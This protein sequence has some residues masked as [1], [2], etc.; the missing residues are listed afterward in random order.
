M[1]QKPRSTR[2]IILVLACVLLCG[3]YYCYDIPAS[4]STSLQHYFKFTEVKWNYILN[5]LYSVYSIPNLVLPICSGLLIDS[6]SPNRTII[7][8]SSMLMIAQVV[9]TMA[10]HYK[11]IPLMLV[12]RALFGIGGEALEVAQAVIVTTW[13]PNNAGLALGLTLTAA[14]L[15]TAANDNI[16]PSIYTHTKTPDAVNLVGVIVAAISVMAAITIAYMTKVN[17]QVDSLVQA[18]VE[19]QSLLTESMDEDNASQ[20]SENCDVASSSRQATSSW[21]SGVHPAFW[22]LCLACIFCYATVNPYMHILQGYLENKYYPGDPVFAARVMSIPDLM[23]AVG[24]PL[25]GLLLDRYGFRSL[26]LPFSSLLILCVHVIVMNTST[27]TPIPYM[28][29]LGLAYSIFAAA[30]WPC[31]PALID[32]QYRATAYGIL[33]VAMNIALTITPVLIGVLMH[34]GGYWLMELGFIVGSIAAV[35]NE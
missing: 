32:R 4:I 15:S 28:I 29:L 14:R 35:H 33:T 18:D 17:L 16:S 34:H 22:P 8:F 3:N 30:L 25:V 26:S 19:Q 9:F 10:T 23:S 2:W 6:I 27:G 24:S 11:N 21:F 1:T 31:V 12:A 20:A 7:M 13:F 5:L